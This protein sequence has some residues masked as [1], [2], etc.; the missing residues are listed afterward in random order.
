MTDTLPKVIKYNI[1]GLRLFDRLAISLHEV[2][3]NRM[4]L[5]HRPIWRIV[6]G[7]HTCY[8]PGFLE[9]FYE[10]PCTISPALFDVATVQIG[11]P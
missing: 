9:D 10:E 6:S 2:E 7:V 8:E 1:P 4:L 11:R 5:V 3:V